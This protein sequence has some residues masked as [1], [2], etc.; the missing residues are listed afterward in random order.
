MLAFTEIFLRNRQSKVFY[1]KVFPKRITFFENT[2]ITGCECF[3]CMVSVKGVTNISAL[4]FV[5]MCKD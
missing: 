5:L 4:A 3:C 2:R 1:V